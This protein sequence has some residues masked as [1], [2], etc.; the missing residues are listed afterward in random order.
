MPTLSE[1][2]QKKLHRKDCPF[3]HDCKIQV[4]KDF[5]SRICN[6]AAYL[7]CHHFARRVGEL[8]TPFRWLQK[9]A[10]DQAK[11]LEHRVEA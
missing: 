10:V 9:F 8:R 4:T 3:I 6:S 2:F 7:N 11:M 5:F 1:A